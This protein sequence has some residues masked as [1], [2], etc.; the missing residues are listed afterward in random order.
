MLVDEKKYIL[1]S[2]KNLYD[3]VEF[4]NKHRGKCGDWWINDENIYFVYEYIK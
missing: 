2:F 1:H 3:C 4:C